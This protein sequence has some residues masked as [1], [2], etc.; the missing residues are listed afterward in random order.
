MNKQ[1]KIVLTALLL[2]VST[3]VIADEIKIQNTYIQFN[4]GA[5]IKS[6]GNVVA[7]KLAAGFDLNKDL[8]IEGGGVALVDLFDTDYD[9]LYLSLVAKHALSEKLIL[10]GKIGVTSWDSTYTPIFS[11][12]ITK[13]NGTSGMAGVDLKYDFSKNFAA[14][15]SVEYFGGTKIMP[16]TGGLRYTF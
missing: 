7:L 6:G 12:T 13:K 3:F 1:L 14:L 11:S 10:V 4:A 8:G 2:S 5:G 9:I 15:L 16:I